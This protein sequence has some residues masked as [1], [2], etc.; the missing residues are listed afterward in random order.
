MGQ[1]CTGD[2]LMEC[3]SK[4]T[5]ATLQIVFL[6]KFVCGLWAKMYKYFSST[7]LTK[8]DQDNLVFGYFPA[9]R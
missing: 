9:I 3:W 5:Q 2:F 1:N 8:A 7:M 6:R 4:Q